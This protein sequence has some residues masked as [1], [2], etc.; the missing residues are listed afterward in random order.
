MSDLGST[1]IE[2]LP[3]I[4][5]DTA[6]NN[7]DNNNNDNKIIDNPIQKLDEERKELF[8]QLGNKATNNSVNNINLQKDISSQIN[9]AGLVGATSL[10][11][12]D[13]P[14]NTATITTDE[15]IQNDFIPNQHEHTDYITEHLSTEDIIKQNIEKTENDLFLDKLYS[16][17]SMPLLI[18]VLYFIFKLPFVDNTYNKMFPFCFSKSGNMKIS[19]YLLSSAVFSFVFYLLKKLIK[20]LNI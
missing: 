3:T 14:I 2:S 16:E 9:K 1:N 17:I 11:S 7:N 19:G 5:E 6:F 13:I 18:S 12:R 20:T 8:T 10:P 4:Q 15:Q